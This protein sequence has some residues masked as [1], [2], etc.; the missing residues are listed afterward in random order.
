MKKEKIKQLIEELREY[1]ES[2]RNDWSEFDGRDLLWE[3]DL[4][5][6]K[7]SVALDIDYKSYYEKFYDENGSYSTKGKYIKKIRQAI[8]K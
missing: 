8:K 5:L 6:T 3:I 7:L 4:W 1:A 2:I